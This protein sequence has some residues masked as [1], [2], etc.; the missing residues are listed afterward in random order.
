MCRTQEAQYSRSIEEIILEAKH[1]VENGTK[2]INLLGQNVNA[3]EYKQ[4]LSH[5]IIEISKIKGLKGLDT[6]HLILLIFQ[7]FNSNV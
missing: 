5:L 3:F 6:P 7:G 2:E 4:K 1:L